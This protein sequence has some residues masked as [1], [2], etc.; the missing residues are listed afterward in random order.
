MFWENHFVREFAR[1]DVPHNH[2]AVV[3]HNEKLRGVMQE[4]HAGELSIPIFGGILY[5]RAVLA[6]ITN[7]V[8][9][10]NFGV[11]ERLHR[12]CPSIDSK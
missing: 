3:L 2:F 4:L 8:H 11:V 10:T 5:A 9:F 7:L 12:F 1:D 6:R